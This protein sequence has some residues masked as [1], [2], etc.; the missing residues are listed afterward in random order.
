MSTLLQKL[1]K[2]HSYY[3]WAKRERDKRVFVHQIDKAFGN[4]DQAFCRRLFV[5]DILEKLFTAENMETSTDRAIADIVAKVEEALENDD[6]DIKDVATTYGPRISELIDELNTSSMKLVMKALTKLQNIKSKISEKRKLLKIPAIAKVL[7]FTDEEVKKLDNL[8]SSLEAKL[9]QNVTRKDII[10]LRSNVAKIKSLL[11]KLA[12]RSSIDLL[13]QKLK[14]KQDEAEAVSK[15][16]SGETLVLN[17]LDLHCVKILGE[18]FGDAIQISLKKE[19]AED[20][21]KRRGA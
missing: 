10:W 1:N 21:S 20:I 3:T 2:V 4:L 7:G 8:T 9:G 13:Q 5:R 15:L 6:Q 17:S 18:I 11:D 14:L 16:I 12:V 19:A